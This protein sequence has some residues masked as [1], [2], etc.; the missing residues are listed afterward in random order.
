MSATRR[1]FSTACQGL[2]DHVDRFVGEVR[3]E[4][5]ALRPDLPGEN[6]VRRDALVEQAP[7]LDAAE[8]LR[9]L[10]ECCFAEP[11]ALGIGDQRGDKDGRRHE[12]SRCS[13]RTNGFETRAPHRRPDGERQ[14]GRRADPRESVRRDDRQRGFDA[15]LCRPANPDRPADPGRGGESAAP[16][17]RGDRRGGQLFGRPLVAPRPGH[18][19]RDRRQA[20]HFRRRHGPLF[21][22]P[23]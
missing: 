13:N 12:A 10:V 4:R 6:H 3:F 21:P 2:H 22:R 5:G 14:V 1:R 9:G 19:R 8:G 7:P 11:F 18:S 20:G 15:G 23:D 16:P 17:L